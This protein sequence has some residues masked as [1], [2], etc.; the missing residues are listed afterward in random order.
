MMFCEP[1]LQAVLVMVGVILAVPAITQDLPP[2][3][4]LLSRVK[5]HMRDELQRLATISC[6][7]TV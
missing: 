5:A 2:G 7:E 6:V 1:G 3:I 4:L